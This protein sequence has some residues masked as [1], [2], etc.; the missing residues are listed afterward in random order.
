MLGGQ[1]NSFE[2]GIRDSQKSVHLVDIRKKREETSVSI[3]EVRSEFDSIKVHS[4]STK[5]NR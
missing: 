4:Q 5:W 2:K 1:E 3:A